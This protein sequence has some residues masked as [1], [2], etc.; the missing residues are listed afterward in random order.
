MKHYHLPGPE[1][2][3]GIEQLGLKTD[4]QGW[5]SSHPE[6]RALVHEVHAGQPGG[7]QTLVEVGSWK[8][9]SAIYL[10]QCRAERPGPWRLICVDTWL[11]SLE[12]WMLRG[13]PGLAVPRDA[14]GWPRLYHQFLHN[15]AA[16]GLADRIVPVPLPSSIGADLLRRVLPA[17]PEFIYLDASHARA[18]VAADLAAWWPLVAPGGLL[19]GDDLA[20]PGV[21]RAVLEFAQAHPAGLQSYQ[22]RD[23]TLWILRK[24][25]AAA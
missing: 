4:L 19:V 3:A 12:H 14:H 10:A 16:V 15:V 13:K 24:R 1:V 11:G 20:L 23:G 22:E 9:A 21:V 2:Y 7:L 18:D 8:G 5:H 25:G 6:L 17:L